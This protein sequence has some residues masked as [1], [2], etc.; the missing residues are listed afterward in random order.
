MNKF[1]AS[2]LYAA[3]L[4]AYDFPYDPSEELSVILT[5]LAATIWPT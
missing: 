4:Q 1:I 5:Q 2:V 3:A